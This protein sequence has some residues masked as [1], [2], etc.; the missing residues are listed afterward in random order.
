MVDS[1]QDAE[2]TK[3][4]GVLKPTNSG[5]RRSE[6]V[7]NDCC[8]CIQLRK[9][10]LILGY[11]S[12]V[13]NV[14]YGFAYIILIYIIASEIKSTSELLENHRS[15]TTFL[16]IYAID[17]ILALISIPFNI[18][19]LNGLHKERRRFVKIYIRFQLVMLVLDILRKL[20][21]MIMMSE[22]LDLLT[23]AAVLIDLGLN[24]YFLLVVRSQYEKMGEAADSLPGQQARYQD[25]R[26][27]VEL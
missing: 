18:L 2:A 9:G 5:E 22:K 12:L 6:A 14:V 3:S 21:A 27:Q 13:G 17:L 7:F 8:C 10:C 19:L 20:V 24:I 1:Q 25:G 23:I 11:M 16:M 26:V 15:N 4:I